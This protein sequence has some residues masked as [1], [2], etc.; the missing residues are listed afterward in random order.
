MKKPDIEVKCD[1]TL[2]DSLKFRHDPYDTYE[3]VV[4]AEFTSGKVK[5]H[6]KMTGKRAA[7]LGEVLLRVYGGKEDG[8]IN[9]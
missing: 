2:G 1:M 4:W 5:H 8:K 9:V 7:A 3:D 6:I